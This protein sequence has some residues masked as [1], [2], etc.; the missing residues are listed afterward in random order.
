MEKLID[1]IE[2]LTLNIKVI[3]IIKEN[4]ITKK[5]YYCCSCRDYHY[6][7]D[8]C[9]ECNR[10]YCNEHIEKLIYDKNVDNYYCYSCYSFI[11]NKYK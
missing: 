10:G 3:R 9:I 8:E 2:D 11:I 5:C 7:I 4:V 6:K 1:T